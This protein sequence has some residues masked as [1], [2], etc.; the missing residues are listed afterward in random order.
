M[1][2]FGDVRTQ[3]GDISGT[4]V[5]A[6][7]VRDVYFAAAP[8]R[9]SLPHRSRAVPEVVNGF[10]RR[11]VPDLDGLTAGGVVLS[12]L[13]GVGKTQTA[14]DYVERVWRAG[15]VELVGWV[16]AAERTAVVAGLTEL[17][18]VVT[19]EPV[20]DETR[21]LDWCASTT[22]RWLLVFD[23]VDDPAELTGLWPHT[24]TSG[25]LVVTT[26]RNEPWLQTARRRLVP[27]DEFSAAES[28]AY[29]R[30]VL[31]DAEGLADLSSL[32][33]HLPLALGQASAYIKMIPG[34]TCDAYIRKWRDERT[35]LARMFPEDWA[36]T[37][38]TTWSISIEAAD[39]LAPAGLARPMLELL[40]LLD[41]NGIPLPVLTSPPICDHLSTDTAARALGCLQR[42]NLIATDDSNVVRVHA[43][44]QHAT[45]DQLPDDRQALLAAVAA[46]ALLESWPTIE[47]D[48]R[49]AAM[50]RANTATLA[51]HAGPHLWRS[52]G[53][54]V[55]FR[56]GRSLG[57][58]GQL[59]AATA[60]HEVLRASAARHL[61]SQ[62]PSTLA[63]R[64]NSARWQGAAG[65]S[66]EAARAFAD[67]LVDCLR[68]LGPDNPDTLTTR[69]NLAYWQG[70]AGD[71]A[72]AANSFA[73]L[74]A[75][76]L[77]VLGPDH[78]HTLATRSS[79]ATWRGEAGDP[80]GAAQAFAEVLADRLRVFEPDHHNTLTTRGNLAR[81]QG[82][83]GDAATAVRA[84]SELLVDCLRVLGPEHPDTLMTRGSL[85]RWRGEAGDPHGAVQASTEL[86]A[87]LLRV[88]GPDHPYTLTTRSNLAHFRGKAGDPAAAVAA[89]EELLA[90]RVR[91]QGSD[92]PATRST[93][94]NLARWREL[95]ETG[96][97]G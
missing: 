14:A 41:P 5:Q 47:R 43:L 3:A 90:D 13:G 20:P 61:G 9:P 35:A 72:K 46:D 55:L 33:G 8:R 16:T 70:M 38:A 78:N 15:E 37:V 58:A 45:R 71:A 26:R 89:H 76:H 4:A 74:L 21:F 7:S 50:L 83:A 56:A 11:S 95:A 36:D 31:G 84:Y 44:V 85:A 64:H 87:D 40:S 25:R 52:D 60:Y 19:G 6:A 69:G 1:S 28:V 67:L 24:G 32:L 66:A 96:D 10:Q 92:H 54:L 94:L 65:H 68:V 2:E 18:Q 93:R 80:A 86:L 63:A 77:R 57:E 59:D 23:D 53:H 22:T 51:T 73:E 34:M 82:E 17:G 81:W 79:L 42:L 29:L 97:L 75:D 12:G 48:T 30:E 62:H 91:V 39:R 27:L 88:L 49:F